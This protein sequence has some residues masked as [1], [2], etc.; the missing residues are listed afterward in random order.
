MLLQIQEID[1][2]EGKVLK[3][4]QNDRISSIKKLNACLPTLKICAAIVE[5]WLSDDSD[6]GGSVT[7][8]HTYNWISSGFTVTLELGKEDSVKTTSPYLRPLKT[9]SLVEYKEKDIDPN[10]ARVT[11]TYDIVGTER[12]IHLE[13]RLNKSVHCKRV[14]TGTREVEQY[15][16]VCDDAIEITEELAE[17]F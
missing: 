7:F 6:R 13:I 4:I 9:S 1:T 16:L 11:A 12:E 10:N 5:S 3:D 15:K 2:F 8:E 17:E 14:V